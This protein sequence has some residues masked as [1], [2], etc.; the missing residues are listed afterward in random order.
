MFRLTFFL[1]LFLSENIFAQ[2]KASI[3]LDL[4]KARANYEVARQQFENDTRLYDEKAISA[5]DYTKSKN[6]LL[7]WEFDS[8]V[9]RQ[10]SVRIGSAR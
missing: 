1:F 9:M 7:S 8:D 5:N 6:N 4:K 10:R 2:D 3:M